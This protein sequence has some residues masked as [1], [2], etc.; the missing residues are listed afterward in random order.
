MK[1][2]KG[3][4][5]TWITGLIAGIAFLGS[6]GTAWITASSK[7]SKEIAKVNTVVQVVKERENNHYREL[8]K[9]LDT[10]TKDMKTLLNRK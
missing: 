2:N 9:K 8:S 3:Q 4:A 1:Y 10:L 7:V 6:I 5:V